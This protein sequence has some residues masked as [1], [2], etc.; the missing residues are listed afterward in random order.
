M[1][2][3][4]ED[5][6][7]KLTLDQILKNLSSDGFSQSLDNLVGIW[8]EQGLS[9]VEIEAMLKKLHQRDAERLTHMDRLRQVAQ[10]IEGRM[11]EREAIQQ[12]ARMV[13]AKLDIEIANLKGRI[14]ELGKV[15]ADLDESIQRRRER[16]EQ[17]E[18]ELAVLE[19]GAVT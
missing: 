8:S 1:A 6:N 17:L 11:K 15:G 4:Q 19:A 16:I 5:K 18:Q 3:S 10:E 9:R 14:A 12:Q 13:I 2:E 7:A